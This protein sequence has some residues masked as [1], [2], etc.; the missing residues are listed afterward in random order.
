MQYTKQNKYNPTGV[1]KQS[2]AIAE[3]TGAVQGVASAS[4]VLRVVDGPRVATFD[5]I[6][7]DRWPRLRFDQP[8]Q[9]ASHRASPRHSVLQLWNCWCR[10]GRCANR[11]ASLPCGIMSSALHPKS[12]VEVVSG[13]WQP[14]F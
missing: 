9:T 3:G 7:P 10:V 1:L 6:L 8:F 14:G 4:W 2:S 11:T 5:G 12:I 13:I